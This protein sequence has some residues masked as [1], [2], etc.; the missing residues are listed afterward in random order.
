LNWNDEEQFYSM[1]TAYEPT[2]DLNNENGWMIRRRI[3]KFP[4]WVD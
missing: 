2:L 3:Q 4:D 1:R